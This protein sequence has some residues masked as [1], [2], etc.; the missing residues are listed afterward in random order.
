LARKA[1]GNDKVIAVFSKVCEH[2]G[3]LRIVGAE[4]SH[5]VP[6]RQAGEAQAEDG[7]LVLHD[8]DSAHGRDSFEQVGKDS[9]A[10]SG[11]KMN[12]VFWLFHIVVLSCW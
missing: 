9:A 8:F 12:R 1:P 3:A 4:G 10:A 5:V 7:S 2:S 6:Y 11:E